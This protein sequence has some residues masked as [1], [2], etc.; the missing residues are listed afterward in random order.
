MPRFSDYHRTVIGYHGT[1]QSVAER[2]VLR[3]EP[4]QWY[5]RP[6]DWMGNGIYYWEYGPKQ[7]WWFAEVRRRQRK[8]TEPVAVVASMI[9]LGFC[10]DLLDPDNAREL[11]SFHD[12]YVETQTALGLPVPENDRRWK[13]LDKAVFE[14]AYTATDEEIARNGGTSKVD[15]C[16]GI[17]VRPGTTGRLWKKSWVQHGAFIQLLVRNP[18]CILGSWLVEPVEG[19]DHEGQVEAGEELAPDDDNPPGSEGVA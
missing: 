11:K 10:F 19:D 13:Y 17:Y 3:R 6:H 5:D 8:W 18:E 14:Y 12:D 15:T 9:R 1:Q 7:A 16:R 2:I 4:F